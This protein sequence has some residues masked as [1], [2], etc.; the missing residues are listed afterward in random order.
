MSDLCLSYNLNLVLLYI[1]MIFNYMLSHYFFHQILGP[2]VHRRDCQLH[3]DSLHGKYQPMN[4][5]C[6]NCKQGL[7]LSSDRYT[8]LTI[9]I[10]KLEFVDR[11]K[12]MRIIFGILSMTFFVFCTN[13]EEWEIFILE[14]YNTFYTFDLTY[15][16]EQQAELASRINPERKQRVQFPEQGQG[17]AVL[18][19]LETPKQ[20]L[21]ELPHL[22]FLPWLLLRQQTKTI[23][24]FLAWVCCQG[25]DS[26]GVG[27]DAH[28]RCPSSPLLVTLLDM[29]ISCSNWENIDKINFKNTDQPWILNSLEIH[30]RLD[31]MWGHS[32]SL[33]IC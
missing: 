8:T 31:L 29:Q 10:R 28:G 25:A 16:M 13:F 17:I 7:T 30:L 5:T 23:L 18:C 4:W 14:K 11:Y 12:S 19:I 15:T 33:D 6:N 21:A 1:C 2:S 22:L 20:S 32:L 26:V 9:D 3:I 24:K 27:R